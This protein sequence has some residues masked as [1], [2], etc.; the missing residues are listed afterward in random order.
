[1]TGVILFG[2]GSPIVIDFEESRRRAGLPL[3]AGIHNR[4]GPSYLSEGARTLSPDE[5]G[6]ELLRLPFL[7]PLFTQGY[8]Q[9]AAREAARYGLQ[10]PFSLVDP[11]VSA[12]PRPWNLHTCG[13]QPRRRQYFPSPSLTVAQASAITRSS[14]ISS[15]S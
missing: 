14:V 12:E 13:R 1:M 6:S 5:L 10:H 4:P 8:R 11:S 9:A 2:V 3:A 7:V 15:R